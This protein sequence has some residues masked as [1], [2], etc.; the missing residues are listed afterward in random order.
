M[1]H[2]VSVE[3]DPK[4]KKHQA[5]YL[6]EALSP[7]SLTLDVGS[8]SKAVWKTNFQSRRI[9]YF[10]NVAPRS[11][12]EFAWSIREKLF[13]NLFSAQSRYEINIFKDPKTGSGCLVKYMPHEAQIQDIPEDPTS[14]WDEVPIRLLLALKEV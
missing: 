8:V 3:M 4:R 1:F 10:V 5:A 12:V 13:P 7:S 14:D 6:S 9:N 2:R 11:V